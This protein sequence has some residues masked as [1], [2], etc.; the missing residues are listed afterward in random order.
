MDHPWCL[1][2]SH[3]NVAAQKCDKASECP[4]RK[5]S[6]D[7]AY[8]PS[9]VASGG[10]GVGYPALVLV[11][12]VWH[13]GWM[14]SQ[15]SGK[16]GSYSWDQTRK[17]FSYEVEA[18]RFIASQGCKRVPQ[19]LCDNRETTIGGAA[20]VYYVMTCAAG[21][22]GDV[23]PRK[24]YRQLLFAI[25]EAL[26]SLH[27]VGFGHYDLKPQNIKFDDKTGFAT[28]IDLGSSKG[29]DN[30]RLKSD[31]HRNHAVIEGNRPG[32]FP[33]VSP[34]QGTTRLVNL[35]PLSDVYAFGVI[36]CQIVLGRIVSATESRVELHRSLLKAGIEKNIAETLAWR[37]LSVET[38]GRRGALEAL[39]YDLLRFGWNE[40]RPAELKPAR[41]LLPALPPEAQD[42]SASD[43]KPDHASIRRGG[44]NVKLIR[45]AVIGAV[46]VGFGFCLSFYFGKESAGGGYGSGGGGGTPPTIGVPGPVSPDTSVKPKP[47]RH[48][49]PKPSTSPAPQ[50]PPP[51]GFCYFCGELLQNGSCRA[52]DYL[53]TDEFM[54]TNSLLREA[55]KVYASESNAWAVAKSDADNALKILEAYNDPIKTWNKDVSDAKAKLEDLQKLAQDWESK[56]KGAVNE[57]N[58]ALIGDYS[59]EREAVI[60]EMNVVSNH[61]AQIEK[62]GPNNV[63]GGIIDQAKANY[64]NATNKL[65][66]V[67]GRLNFAKVAVEDCSS[68]RL[69]AV[70]F[71]KNAY[72]EAQKRKEEQG[73]KEIA[74]K[75]IELLAQWGD[76]LSKGMP[77]LSELQMEMSSER[78][79]RDAAIE[80]YK[81]NYTA[82]L[83]KMHVKLP[84]DID[85]RVKS[86]GNDYVADSLPFVSGDTNLVYMLP[87]DWDGG[88]FDVRISFKMRG[89]DCTD[90]SGGGFKNVNVNPFSSTPIEVSGD[91]SS[92]SSK[93]NPSFGIKSIYPADAKVEWLLADSND[94]LTPDSLGRVYASPHKKVQVTVSKNGYKTEV[95]AFDDLKSYHRGQKF[96]LDSISLVKGRPELTEKK[97]TKSTVN[98]IAKVPVKWIVVNGDATAYSDAEIRKITKKTDYKIVRFTSDKKEYEEPLSEEYVNKFGWLAEIGCKI[99][100]RGFL[101]GN[102]LSRDYGD[103]SKPYFVVKGND[104]AEGS[105]AIVEE[106][107]FGSEDELE[108]HWEALLQRGNVSDKERVIKNLEEIAKYDGWNNFTG[109]YWS[110]NPTLYPKVEIRLNKDSGTSVRLGIPKE[111][112]GGSQDISS[113]SHYENQNVN[114]PFGGTKDIVFEVSRICEIKSCTECS[115]PKS[116]TVKV[117]WNKAAVVY[118][119]E[120]DI[121]AYK[122]NPTVIIPNNIRDGWSYELGEHEVEKNNAGAIDVWPHMSGRLTAT[123]DGYESLVF[124]IPASARGASIPLQEKPLTQKSEPGKVK[125]VKK[126]NSTK[127]SFVLYIRD[128]DNRGGKKVEKKWDGALS[129]YEFSMRDLSDKK[130]SGTI[131]YCVGRAGEILDLNA[132]WSSPIKVDELKGA[133]GKIDVVEIEPPIPLESAPD[134]KNMD[135]LVRQIDHKLKY[136]GDSWVDNWESDAALVKL[137]GDT[138]KQ[139]V[140]HVTSNPNCEIGACRNIDRSKPWRSLVD[141][142][143][144]IWRTKKP[145][146]KKDFFVH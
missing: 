26:L 22:D 44:N 59:K 3:F 10:T 6:D 36:F 53:H 138:I 43:I 42:V 105:Y 130:K 66:E 95:R 126:K 131:Q 56:I 85:A 35:T 84:K 143:K 107:S 54:A 18:L 115:K 120:N 92:L 124:D 17:A 9:H 13:Q 122:P 14:K 76:D 47:S 41:P 123:R 4:W 57:G 70:A 37:I 110:N 69:A 127:N 133:S 80:F 136:S 116:L 134:P 137:H 91:L 39:F 74:K 21:E 102:V 7:V 64:V 71:L 141:W 27:R 79:R 32:T 104:I 87:T 73:I 140:K 97:I 45:N 89:S 94:V 65:M 90:C 67:E 63:N 139:F 46:L 30:W 83:P 98:V 99:Q 1:A 8:D 118:L 25:C 125:F 135:R 48:D 62:N 49:S 61:L 103:G 20:H 77:P 31:R 144:E 109:S 121:P 78:W 93:P 117:Q 2:C 86:I 24:G 96:D 12:G 101:S 129:E 132:K 51:S 81:S 60:S 111:L 146:E 28:L 128:A 52:K 16:T 58:Y 82:L 19:V 15:E 106:F 113:Y 114:V 100:E 29:P 145:D 34:E 33:Y 142:V 108:N 119:A 5:W 11:K 68:N 40:G 50:T 75:R 112:G 55:I 23:V 72:D 38:S 88:T